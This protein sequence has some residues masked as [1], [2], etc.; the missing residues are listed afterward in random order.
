LAK[1]EAF[2]HSPELYRVGGVNFV[3]GRRFR[4]RINFPKG[5]GVNYQFRS[6]QIGFGTTPPR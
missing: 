2:R 6:I 4:F 1:G 5:V 3:M